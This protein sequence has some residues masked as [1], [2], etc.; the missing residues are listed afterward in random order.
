MKIQADKEGIS[1]INQLCDIALKH[2][3]LA[4]LNQ[5]NVI[6]QSVTEIK[7]EEKPKDG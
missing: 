1:V 5:I 6:L 3:G 7:E 2:V 4:C